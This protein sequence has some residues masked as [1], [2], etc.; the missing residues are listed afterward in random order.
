MDESSLGSGGSAEE[1]SEGLRSERKGW[2]T[3][4]GVRADEILRVIADDLRRKGYMD[5]RWVGSLHSRVVDDFPTLRHALESAISGVLARYYDKSTRDIQV[6]IDVYEMDVKGETR[7]F[8][9]TVRRKP[10]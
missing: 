10:R 3:D 9:L 1:G 8:D 7:F 2:K 6:D 5:E 4:Q